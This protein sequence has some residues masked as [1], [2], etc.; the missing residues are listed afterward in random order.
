MAVDLATGTSGTL[1]GTK[2]GIMLG[3]AGAGGTKGAV[4]APGAGD[5]AAGKFLKAD[6][7]WGVPSVNPLPIFVDNETPTGAVPGTV[8]TLAHAPSPAASLKLYKGNG[9]GG[10]VLLKAGGVDYALVGLTITLGSATITG[11]YL[12]ADYRY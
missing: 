1:Q 5:A 10:S 6:A 4:P 3:D 8:Y 11:D 9:T 2:M 12:L 7:S